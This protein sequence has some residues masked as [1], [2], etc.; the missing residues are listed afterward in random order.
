MYDLSQDPAQIRVVANEPRYASIREELHQ[1]VLDK[2]QTTGDPRV[3]DGGTFFES[4][5]QSG[6]IKQ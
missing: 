4:L 6:P 2:L 5:P 1:R 3:Q